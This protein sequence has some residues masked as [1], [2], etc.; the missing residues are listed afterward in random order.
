MDLSYYTK[1]GL[2]QNIKP[3]S[4]IMKFS[5][6]KRK[7]GFTL[8]E[9]LVVIAIVGVLASVI[10][11]SLNSA[12]GKAHDARR[13]SD[14][15]NMNLAMQLYYDKYGRYPTSPNN[16]SSGSCGPTN[17]H[18]ESFEVVAQTLV[19]EGFL[20]AVPKD[21]GSNCY[22]LYDYGR[23]SSPGQI[24]VAVLESINATTEG[25]YGS[26]RPFT[27]NWCSYTQLSTNYCLCHTY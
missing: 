25:P 26:C 21:P 2:T 9:L 18:Q 16:Y 6:I 27:T 13:V 24:M 12:R 8:I 20:G 22:M 1:T 17:T 11:A 3:V 4:N 19:D 10:L 14:F 23:G 5:C 7:E 15:K